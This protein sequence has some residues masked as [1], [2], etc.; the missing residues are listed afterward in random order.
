MNLVS[1]Q[2]KK[3]FDTW[4]N[5]LKDLGYSTYW[6]V[7]NSADFGMTQARK[8]VYAVSILDNK[9]IISNKL[10]ELVI[11]KIT[12]DNYKIKKQKIKEIIDFNNK[13]IE[14]SI[15]SQI[16]NTPSRLRMIDSSL[17]ITKDTIKT[18][19]LTTKQDRLPN[20]GVVPFP[21]KRTDKSGILYTNYRFIQAR[22]SYRLMG[23]DE[24]DYWNAKA[25]IEKTI[26]D[27]KRIETATRDI[28]WK[29]AGNS[30][31]VNVIEAIFYWISKSEE[32]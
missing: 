29:Q 12:N 8:R 28:I 26:E 9:K 24:K 3:S 13:F 10:N 4:L 17:L 19:T 7:L 31:A 30:I 14:E 23:F 21:Y 2:H 16:K 25:I 6:G 5:K 27:S 22:E 15:W 1:K 20:A 11:E 32:E 18:P